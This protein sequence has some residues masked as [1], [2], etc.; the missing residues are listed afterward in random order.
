VKTSEELQFALEEVLMA[1]T[2]QNKIARKLEVLRSSV[3][4]ERYPPSS[5]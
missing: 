3:G 1:S 2:R 5:L 4:R